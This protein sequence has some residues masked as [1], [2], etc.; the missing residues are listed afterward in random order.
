[1]SFHE[2]NVSPLQPH[3]TT[4]FVMGTE[5]VKLYIANTGVFCSSLDRYK[6]LS[7]IR[8]SV[9]SEYCTTSKML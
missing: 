2:Y 7:N 6:L 5:F 3:L 8:Q 9:D 1:M 4:V